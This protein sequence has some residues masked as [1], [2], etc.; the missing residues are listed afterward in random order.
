MGSQFN[1]IGGS[2]KTWRPITLHMKYHP[3]RESLLYSLV[4]DSNPA[5][6]NHTSLLEVQVYHGALK[7]PWNPG[8]TTAPGY[9]ALLYAPW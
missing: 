8:P 7:A 4:S 2:T 9:K 6:A 3:N 1:H 5:L